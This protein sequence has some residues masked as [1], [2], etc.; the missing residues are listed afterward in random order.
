MASCTRFK[1]FGAPK[2]SLERYN[3]SKRCDS[4]D[5][6]KTIADLQKTKVP[7]RKMVDLKKAEG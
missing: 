2:C 4:V 6:E 3:K 5:R 1:R 7:F